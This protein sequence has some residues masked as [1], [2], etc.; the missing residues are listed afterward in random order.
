MLASHTMP[1]MSARC[2]II[3]LRFTSNRSSPRLLAPSPHVYQSRGRL[4][5]SVLT[6]AG[7][8]LS[9]LSARL[10]IRP[11][12]PFPFAPPNRHDKR[13]GRRGVVVPALSAVIRFV[14]TFDCV[15]TG[16]GGDFILRPVALDC[17][18]CLPAILRLPGNTSA[19]N[20][21]RHAVGSRSGS[22]VSP[23]IS[24]PLRLCIL[25]PIAPPRRPAPS[26]RAVSSVPFPCS[27]RP[28]RPANR[29]M[30]SQSHYPSWRSLLFPPNCLSPITPR[31]SCRVSGA[32]FKGIEFDAFTICIA[33]RLRHT[34]CL[35]PCGF[36]M[37][38]VGSS[39]HPHRIRLAP[40]LLT[41]AP[42]HHGA[43]LRTEQP[44]QSLP[45]SRPAYRV[46][47]RGGRALMSSDA[48][49]SIP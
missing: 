44:P 21:G 24:Y 32:D 11:S 19:V 8:R 35:P 9:F 16:D 3:R 5:R 18:D 39:H 42:Y 27:I 31:L 14:H 43:D 15:G 23:P 46:G 40:S 38:P 26:P 29:P 1:F 33:E 20:A 45:A 36:H 22:I 2:G 41:A 30:P 17:L 10:P 12:V 49:R 6:A 47:E 25:S 4:R 13:G 7:R 28:H 48:M 37:P 34:A